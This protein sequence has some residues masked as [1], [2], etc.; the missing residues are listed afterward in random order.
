MFIVKFLEFGQEVIGQCLCSL[1][2][3]KIV[4]ILIIDNPNQKLLEN[5]ELILLQLSK[6]IQDLV[7]EKDWLDK[8]R[9]GIH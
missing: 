7:R 5:V 8:M 2:S 4:V 9:V 6:S 1:M 3:G